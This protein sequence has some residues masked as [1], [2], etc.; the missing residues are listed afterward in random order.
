MKKQLLLSVALS[1]LLSVSSLFAGEFGVELGAKQSKL[2]LDLAYGNELVRTKVNQDD[3]GMDDKA[4]LFK[5][6]LYYKSGNH[7]FDFDFEALDYKGSKNITRTINFDNKV[8]AIDSKVDSTLKINWYRLGYKYSLIN[9]GSSYLNLGFDVNILDSKVALK[10]DALDSSYSGTIP[11]PTL[12][13][14]GNYAFNEYFGLEA[15]LAGI[16]VGSKADYVEASA[17][18]NMKCFLLD[19]AN[20]RLAYQNKE[21]NVDVD[22]LDAKLGFKGFLLGFNYKF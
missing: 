21:L 14:S 2:D 11:V 18:I 15:R 5:P 20:W 22:D 4:T 12:V 7:S 3:L 8:Y 19:N 1:S 16:K 17:G 6:T 9:K 13:L 10:T